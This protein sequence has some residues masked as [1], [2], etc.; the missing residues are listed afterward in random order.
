MNLCYLLV[1]FLVVQTNAIDVEKYLTLF[2][3]ETLTKDFKNN[4][5]RI[6]SIDPNYYKPKTLNDYNFDC[7]PIPNEPATSV[8]Q[9]KPSDVK[10]VAAL[11]DSLTAAAGKLAQNIFN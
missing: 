3:I 5:D 11:G 1:L 2:N 6:L 7:E 10:I 9:L 8:D 4:I